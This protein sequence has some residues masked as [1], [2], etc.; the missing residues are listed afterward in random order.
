VNRSLAQLLSLWLAAL[1]FGAVLAGL[2][3][4]RFA[5]A[6]ERQRGDILLDVFGEFRTVLAR[7]LWFKMDLFHEVLDDQGVANSQQAEVLPLLRMVSLLDPSM[8]DAYDNIA[9]DLYKGHRQAAQALAILDEGLERNPQ[10][11]QLRFRRSLVCYQDKQY[12]AAL[13]SARKAVDLAVDEFDKL[14]SNRMVYWSAKQLGDRAAM[15]VALENLL[16]LRPNE[17]QW[18]QEFDQLQKAETSR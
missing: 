12:A 16:A 7:Y 3:R 8:T 1:L 11:F 13:E 2:H 10:S 6:A 17:A 4:T 18:Q 14:N 5:A 9:W 15:R